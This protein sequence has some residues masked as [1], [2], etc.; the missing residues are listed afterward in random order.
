MWR[1]A[2][3]KAAKISRGKLS[4]Y[5]SKA[6]L[7]GSGRPLAIARAIRLACSFVGE[8]FGWVRL[9]EAP[10]RII[11]MIAGSYRSR[12]RA[13]YPGSEKTDR[14]TGIR[15]RGHVPSCR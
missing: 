14:R 13:L 4:Q 2:P 6:S 11:A 1:A 10:P 3:A 9:I 12:P 8:D 7:N 15:Y 5:R